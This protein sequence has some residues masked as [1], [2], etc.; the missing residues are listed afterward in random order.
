MPKKIEKEKYI[1]LKFGDYQI[2]DQVSD[3]NG[4][5]LWKCKCSCGNERHLTLRSLLKGFSKSCGCKNKREYKI[6]DNKKYLKCS[7]CN[8]FKSEENFG[9]KKNSIDGRRYKCKNCRSKEKQDLIY[10]KE[11]YETHKQQH[12]LK[13]KEYVSKNRNKIELY[14]KQWF[15]TNA[16]KCKKSNKDRYER[17]KHTEEFKKK[18]REN[19]K[20]YRKEKPYKF[21]IRN[22][23]NNFLKK[24]FLKKMNRTEK[25]LGYTTEE[26]RVH[27][28]SLWTEGM[29]W[30]NYGKLE[31][32]SYGWTIDHIKPISAYELNTDPKIV[33]S[34][35]NLR[36]MWATTRTINGITYQGNLN[37]ND[38]YNE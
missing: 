20:K 13:C 9:I 25:T 15:E 5:Y 38:K 32:G 4:R 34:L 7:Q 8:D 10:K 14:K 1:G 21:A 36:P 23:L 37:K 27:I 16:D 31:D 17:I 28:E 11:W 18:N 19:Q 12:L 26:F 24:F 35:S 29:S 30:N 3:G 2:L 6:I 22:V 33:N